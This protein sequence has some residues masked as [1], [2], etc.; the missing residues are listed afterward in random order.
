MHSLCHSDQGQSRSIGQSILFQVTNLLIL[1]LPGGIIMQVVREISAWVRK[2]TKHFTMA[3]SI[4]VNMAKMC[5][6]VLRD[7]DNSYK[8]SAEKNHVTILDG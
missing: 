5:Q 7:F 6:R 3:S 2:E 4:L 8:I 1:V